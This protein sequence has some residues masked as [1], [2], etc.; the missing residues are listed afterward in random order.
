MKNLLAATAV[1][2][3]L[4]SAALAP[5]LAEGPRASSGNNWPGM[6]QRVEPAAAPAAVGHWAWEITYA[7]GGKPRGAW[8]FVP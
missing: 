3:L 8:V 4:A 1:A 6:S 2:G 5:A 7:H